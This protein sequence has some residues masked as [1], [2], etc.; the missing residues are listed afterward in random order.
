MSN[1]DHPA[2]L[3]AKVTNALRLPNGHH[4]NA[5][6]DRALPQVKDAN[7]IPLG[8]VP[9]D[10]RK[11]KGHDQVVAERHEDR[12]NLQFGGAAKNH[13]HPLVS[14]HRVRMLRLKLN[15]LHHPH[16]HKNQSPLRNFRT[17]KK[18]AKRP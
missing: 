5:A 6:P 7:N 18:R 2:D 3:G 10:Q 12:G 8:T 14:C 1:E 17:N 4:G 13:P 9:H 11:G 16:G 15:G